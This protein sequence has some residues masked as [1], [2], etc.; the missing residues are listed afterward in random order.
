MVSLLENTPIG[1]SRSLVLVHNWVVHVVLLLARLLLCR[2]GRYRE[3]PRPLR[4]PARLWRAARLTEPKPL[5][6]GAEEFAH[7]L[8]GFADVFYDLVD[9]FHYVVHNLAG[10]CVD[11]LAA[12]RD[13]ENAEGCVEA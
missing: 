10:D 12:V 11:D 8:E 3:M 4:S 7:I 1:L 9:L 6:E 13:A 5:P 2:S